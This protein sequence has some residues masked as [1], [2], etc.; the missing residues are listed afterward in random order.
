MGVFCL[1]WVIMSNYRKTELGL[2]Y[3]YCVL[4][5]MAF[6]EMKGDSHLKGPEFSVLITLF[7]DLVYS[8]GRG[9]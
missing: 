3:L 8:C 4:L 7:Y 9:G 1:L 5:K 2:L 6:W